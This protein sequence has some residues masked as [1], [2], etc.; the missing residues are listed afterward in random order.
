[1]NAAAQMIC[2]GAGLM[3]LAVLT[4]EPGRVNKSHVSAQSLAALIY[5]IVFGSWIAYSAYIWLLKASTPA[6]VATYAYVNP[7]IAIFLGRVILGE[8]LNTRAIWAAM[9]IVAGVII[10]TLPKRQ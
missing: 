1:M 2:G 3:L 10:T 9:I 7:V 6:R 5:L 4:G 8:L